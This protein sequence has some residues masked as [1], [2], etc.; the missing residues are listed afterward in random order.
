[1][2]RHPKRNFNLRKVRVT[3]VISVGALAAG[4]V[5]EVALTDVTTSSIRIMSVDFAYSLANLGA[6]IDDS[7]EFGLAHGD[8]TATE[9]EECLEANESI[10]R[11]DKIADEKANR[12]VRT[13]GIMTGD[14]IAGAGLS[15]NDGRPMKTKLNWAIDT[16]LA[17]SFWIRNGSGSVY[18]TGAQIAVVGN[19]WVKDTV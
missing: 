4:D 19:M 2:A 7:Q 11:N 12:I 16:G 5:T 14:G 15:F 17:L 1:M 9:I 13:I 8:Y 6:A 18:T 3:T 10:N